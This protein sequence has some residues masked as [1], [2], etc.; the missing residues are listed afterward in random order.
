MRKMK[1]ILLLLCVLV[2]ALFLTN[3]IQSYFSDADKADNKITIGGNNIRIEEEFKPPSTLLPGI[4][5]KKDV[6]VTNDGPNDCYVRIKAVF[7]DSDMEKYCNV[8]WNIYSENN[9]KGWIYNE[10]DGYY[11]YPVSIAVSEKTSSLFT[12]ITMK[13]VYDNE[14]VTA[15]DFKDFDILVYAESFQADGFDNYEEAWAY[16]H[17]NKPQS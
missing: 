1:Y 3:G 2:T 9:L 10:E 7:T 16:Y 11:Y 15:K 17:R 5:F 4:S 14:T 8:D 13:E 6:K 12:T